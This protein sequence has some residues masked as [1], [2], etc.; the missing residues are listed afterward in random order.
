LEPSLDDL[1]KRVDSKYA[2]VVAAAKR[3]RQ[4]TEARERVVDGSLP[5]PVSLAL[6]EIARGVLEVSVP[7]NSREPYGT[8]PDAGPGDRLNLAG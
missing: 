4:I 6:D 5:K 8:S 2:L 1:M 3:G 7:E